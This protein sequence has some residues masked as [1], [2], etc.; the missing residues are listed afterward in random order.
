M[1]PEG[2]QSKCLVNS[3]LH[4]ILECH[5][6]LPNFCISALRMEKWRKIKSKP[7]AQTPCA[8]ESLRG[9]TDHLSKQPPQQAG[10]DPGLFVLN[11]PT[12]PRPSA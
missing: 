7:S 4:S 12:E 5:E 6:G 3:T 2:K 8:S 9:F 11:N 1:A 10:A